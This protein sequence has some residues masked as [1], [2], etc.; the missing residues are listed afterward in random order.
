MLKEYLSWL[1]ILVCVKGISKLSLSL[2]VSGLI[3]CMREI[4]KLTIIIILW[5][6]YLSCLY[7]CLMEG[8]SRLSW[9]KKISKLSFYYYLYEGN[10]QA[11]LKLLFVWRNYLSWLIIIILWRGY[12]NCLFIIICTMGISKLSWNYF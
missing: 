2:F 10:I 5:R 8:I 6:E 9:I 12:L 4:S 1:N 11:V 7:H 3:I